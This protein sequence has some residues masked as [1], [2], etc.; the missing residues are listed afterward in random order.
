MC[1]RL[2]N[3]ENT[4]LPDLGGIQTTLEKRTRHRRSLMRML[5]DCYDTD[6]MIVCM[7]PSNLDLMHDFCSDRSVTRVLEIQCD[8]SD[9]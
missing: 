7:D 6:R 2:N 5:F 3:E 4:P 9:A 1:R 8:F